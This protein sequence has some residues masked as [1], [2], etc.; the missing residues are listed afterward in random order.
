MWCTW[1]SSTAIAPQF[2]IFNIKPKYLFRC[3]TSTV[4]RHGKCIQFSRSILYLR[5]TIILCYKVFDRNDIIETTVAHFLKKSQVVKVEMFFDLLYRAQHELARIMISTRQKKRFKTKSILFF[6]SPLRFSLQEIWFTLCILQIFAYFTPELFRLF[7]PRT[8]PFAN[9]S[10]LFVKV[11]HQIWSAIR[12]WKF[13]NNRTW[14]FGMPI[15]WKIQDFSFWPGF[16]ASKKFSGYF[17]VAA[18]VIFRHSHLYVYTFRIYLVLYGYKL[19]L[20]SYV[21]L[22]IRKNVQ[23]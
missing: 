16:N 8:I 5:Q 1:I 7:C 19:F 13:L 6:L 9:H 11:R 20:T 3:L 18:Y 15:S 12:F 10:K 22:K 21:G 17:G 14:I 4:L 23:L 2:G